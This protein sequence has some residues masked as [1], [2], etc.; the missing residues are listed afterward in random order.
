M[1]LLYPVLL[2]YCDI[3]MELKIFPF[4]LSIILFCWNKFPLKKKTFCLS[5]TACVN[6]SLSENFLNWLSLAVFRSILCSEL[7]F[8]TLK[9]LFNFLLVLSIRFILYLFKGEVCLSLIAYWDHN[10]I[11]LCFNSFSKHAHESSI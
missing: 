9:A 1:E 7:F 4:F 5:D 2:H 8:H 3:F 6:G 10:H 11:P